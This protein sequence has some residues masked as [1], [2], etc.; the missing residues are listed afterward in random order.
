MLTPQ[1]ATFFSSALSAGAI[2]TGFCGT[3]L[4]FRIQR[5]A[6]YHRQP[7]LDF[8]SKK[9][10]DVV[11]G[12]SHFSSS[13]LMLILAS[14]VT[15]V[16]GFCAPLLVLAGALENK[17]TAPVVSGGLLAG[18][19]L[20]CGYFF[21]EMRHYNI[22]SNRLVHDRTEWGRQGVAVAVFVAVAVAVYGVVAHWL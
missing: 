9:A 10:K 7:A 3:F 20:I 2:L 12:L 16:F 4:S 22:L 11:I 6:A 15:I 8:K 17:I 19:A 21:V 14:L 1:D 13:F 5:E 18:L